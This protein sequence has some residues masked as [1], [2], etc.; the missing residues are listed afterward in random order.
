MT[1]KSVISR[2]KQEGVLPYQKRLLNKPST[3]NITP[4]KR[5]TDKS[6]VKRDSMKQL[7]K[8][9][10][11]TNFKVLKPQKSQCNITRKNSKERRGSEDILKKSNRL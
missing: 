3:R 2:S 8:Q 5:T 9:N 10:T 4:S 1:N 6:V 7:P 11:L